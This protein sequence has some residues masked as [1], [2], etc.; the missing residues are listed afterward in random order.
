M[1]NSSNS[2]ILKEFQGQVSSVLI[3]HKSILDIM[4]KLEEYN[5]RI[6]RAVA[7]S[8]TDCGCI[9]IESSKQNYSNVSLEEMLT[10]VKSHISGE[11]CDTCREVINDEIGSYLFYLAALCDSLDLD[12]DNIVKDE[13]NTIKTLGVF[14]LK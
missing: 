1:E 10:T 11:I 9:Q 3:R 13:Y 8:V 4:T 2:N 12:L 14:S 5:S 7:K 6:N